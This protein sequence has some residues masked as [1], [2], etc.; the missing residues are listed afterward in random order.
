MCVLV[1]SL[2]HCFVFWSY[3]IYD[4]SISLCVCVLDMLIILHLK[5]S[6]AVSDRVKSPEAH[7]VKTG[8][9]GSREPATGD[10]SYPS[11]ALRRKA[12]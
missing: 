11:V 6:I 8:I 2:L 1:C 5:R 4:I 3:I 7:I 12:C 10:I 9:K